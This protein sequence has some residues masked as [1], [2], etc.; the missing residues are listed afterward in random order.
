MAGFSTSM[1]DLNVN[2]SFICCSAHRCITVNNKGLQY[3]NA[4]VAEV[5]ELS[6]LLVGSN[7]RVR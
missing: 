2:S 7:N 1:A 6:Q 5:N 4:T 3:S